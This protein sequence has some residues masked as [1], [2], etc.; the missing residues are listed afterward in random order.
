MGYD[1]PEGKFLNRPYE[2]KKFKPK[3]FF[4]NFVKPEAFFPGFAWDG[5][6]WWS[7]GG[8]SSRQRFLFSDKSGKICF[9]QKHFDPS[10]IYVNFDPPIRI[11][12]KDP[13]R[14]FACPTYGLG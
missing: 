6:N 13:R 1:P 5:K 10:H 8:N 12:G 14:N 9:D 4:S 11:F 3:A 2:A 7:G